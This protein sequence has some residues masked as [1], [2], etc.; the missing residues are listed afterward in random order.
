MPGAAAVQGHV[1]ITG[2]ST[3][4]GRCCALKLASIRLSSC[5]PA[6]GR[7]SDG[8]SLSDRRARPARAFQPIRIDVTDSDSIATAA[9]ELETRVGETVA[10]VGSVVNNAG[11]VVLGPVETV[12]LDEWRTTV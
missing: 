6:Y 9:A 5:T 1:L 4:I 12:P 10:A 8:E 2:A 7:R 11:V 3:G